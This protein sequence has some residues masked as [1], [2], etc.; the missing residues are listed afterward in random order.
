[1]FYLHSLFS[2]HHHWLQL[3]RKVLEHEFPKKSGPIVLYFAV[4]YVIVVIET[5]HLF[6]KLDINILFMTLDGN[7][8]NS[9]DSYIVARR[10]CLFICFVA[11]HG[12]MF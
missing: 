7:T 8:R 4:R 6:T 10:I 11:L 12:Q 1:M 3:D 5:N 9:F 2:A